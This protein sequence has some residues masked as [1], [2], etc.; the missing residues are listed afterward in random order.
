MTETPDNLQAIW[1]EIE[2]RSAP[3]DL[4]PTVK[5]Q[6]WRLYAVLAMELVMILVGIAV[7]LV[8]VV[9]NPEPFW[10]AWALDLWIVVIVSAWFVVAKI[11]NVLSESGLS[12]EGY[13]K[14]MMSRHRNEIRASRW[15]IAAAAAQFVILPGLAWWQVAAGTNVTVPRLIAG[16][17]TVLVIMAIYIA[18]MRRT[19][20]RSQRQLEALREE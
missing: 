5:R 13:N 19:L 20:L 12:T 4:Q 7:P 6:T 18:V 2:P 9:R 16:Y 15:G 17:G 1:Q 14:L 10:I 8:T 11:R 3:R